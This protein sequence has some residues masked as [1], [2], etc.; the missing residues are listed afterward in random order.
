MLAVTDDERP[1]PVP[2]R[3][4]EFEVVF[5][6]VNG[7]EGHRAVIV[8]PGG[9]GA[10]PFAEVEDGARTSSADDQPS[11]LGTLVAQ[12]E[13][14]DDAGVGRDNESLPCLGYG[15]FARGRPCSDVF[16]GF[17]LPV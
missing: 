15:R 1:L 12:S 16:D 4:D 6:R 11:Q 3:N 5:V 10:L 2:L 14:T 17:G 13:L 7:E 8:F 9:H